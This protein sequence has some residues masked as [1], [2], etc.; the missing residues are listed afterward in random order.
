MSQAATNA[1]AAFCSNELVAGRLAEVFG[2]LA[3][4]TPQHAAGA[5]AAG[6]GE[7]IDTTNTTSISRSAADVA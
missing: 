1:L 2:H 5:A 3:M 7:S 6:I 4:A